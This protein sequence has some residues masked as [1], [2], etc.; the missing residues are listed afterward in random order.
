VSRRPLVL[1]LATMACS[2]SSEEASEDPRDEAITN[3]KVY[4]G[5]QLDGLVAATERLQAAAPER[6]W[7]DQDVRAMR[8]A[9]HDARD[10]YERVEG[11]IA[12]L[13]PHLDVRV[14]ERYDG[15]VE[16]LADRHLFNGR[17]VTGMHAVERILWAGEHPEAVVRFESA[18]LRYVEARRPADAEEARLFRDE[19]VGQLVRD[20]R[21]MRDQFRPLAID[22]AAAYRGLLGSVEE[23]LEK[24]LLAAT[25]EDESRY[26]QRT[27]ADMR[28]N[29]AGGRAIFEAVRP[30]LGDEAVAARIEA[31]WA[32]LAEAYAIE[33]DAIPEVPE[34][35]SPESGEA[36]SAFGR[37]H[38]AVA[39]EADPEEE[40]SLMS[41]LLEGARAMDV[42]VVPRTPAQLRSTRR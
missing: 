12:M 20:C 22:P 3:V 38:A 24:V 34:G 39:R 25:G 30:A 40:G 19:L 6:T 29:L 36:T 35:W 28:E 27:L 18:L 8:A 9:W 11:A 5:E 10:A 2:S 32:R 33:G 41:A 42:A 14:D 15:F 21:T 1:L 17:G 37:L 26:S 31:G 7:R 23:Q 16:L 4:V 13:F